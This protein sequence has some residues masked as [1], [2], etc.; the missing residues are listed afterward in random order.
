MVTWSGFIP[1]WPKRPHPPNWCN[2]GCWVTPAPFT[3]SKEKS[4]QY[5]LC[6]L[7]SLED[8]YIEFENQ[9][10]YKGLFKEFRLPLFCNGQLWQQRRSLLGSMFFQVFILHWAAV[11]TEE[12]SSRLDVLPGFVC[13]SSCTTCFV[14]LLMGL[15]PRISFLR[16]PN[17][18]FCDFSCDIL[19]GVQPVLFI[20]LVGSLAGCFSFS[21]LFS[22]WFQLWD[23]QNNTESR[24]VADDALNP[25]PAAIPTVRGSTDHATRYT[26]RY[27][28]PVGTLDCQPGMIHSRSSLRRPD[29]LQRLQTATRSARSL[30][31]AL[32][33]H[34]ATSAYD[35]EDIAAD[36]WRIQPRLVLSAPKAVF[37]LFPA[38]IH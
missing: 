29:T 25:K 28:G 31:T 35:G 9:T 33:S 8:G 1:K 13:Q 11:A 17:C 32:G 36:H 23:L 38:F 24:E 10:I 15:G 7:K 14:L 12:V 27:R 37:S 22:R 30:R 3:L 34:L 5:S 6:Q 26:D 21:Y 18:G 19:F 2:G 16:A 4:L 20:L